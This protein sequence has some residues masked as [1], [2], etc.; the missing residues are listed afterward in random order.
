[1]KIEVR[2]KNLSTE[3][4]LMKTPHQMIECADEKMSITRN[5]E[6]K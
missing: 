5:V 2:M 6:N 4:A 3:L 1:M